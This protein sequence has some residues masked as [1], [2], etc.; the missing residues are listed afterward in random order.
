V[1]ETFL[2]NAGAL[3]N[4]DSFTAKSLVENSEVLS[5]QLPEA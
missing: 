5:S 3:S 2:H 1:I 4:E